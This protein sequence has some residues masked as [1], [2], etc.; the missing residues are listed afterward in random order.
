MSLLFSGKFLPKVSYI[1]RFKNP[2]S[3]FKSW[4]IQEQR[5]WKPFPILNQFEWDCVR[6]WQKAVTK[7]F[8]KIETAYKIS[9]HL[10]YSDN[11]YFHVFL[12]VVWLSLNFARF[13][14]IQFQTEPDSFSFL[15]W[16]IKKV[17][18]LKKN[19]LRPLSISKQNSFVYWLNFPE[20]F[21]HKN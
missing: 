16:K 18:F 8:G 11:C 7:T 10:A 3:R 19:F 5:I 2:G 21:I 15:S 1:M 14:E 6:Q 20:G 4:I 13:H 12:S 17:L 9:T